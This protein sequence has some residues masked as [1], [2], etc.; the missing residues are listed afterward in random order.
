MQLPP[1]KTSCFKSFFK[2]SDKSTELKTAEIQFAVSVACHCSIL[3]IDHIGE[4]IQKSCK[5][6]LSNLKLHR[7]KCTK[8]ISNVV[9][10][11]LSEELKKDVKGQPFSLMVDES[12]DCSSEKLLCVCIRYFSD[13]KAEIVTAFLSLIPVNRTTGEALFDAVKKCLEEYELDLCQCIGFASDGANNM[14]GERN[15]LWSRIKESNPNCIQLKCICHSLALC[16]QKAFNKLPS[17]LDFLLSEVASWFSRSS[18]RRESYHEICGIMNPDEAQISSNPFQK[19]AL[20]RW[21]SRGKVMFNL[22]QNW[23][24]LK[25]YFSIVEVPDDN[26]AK[27]RAR[28]IKDMLFDDINYL[29][30]H[31][32]Y[33]IVAEFEKVNAM[34]QST[35]ADPESLMKELHLHHQSLKSRLYDAAGNSFSMNLIGFGAKFL[36]ETQRCLRQHNA[37]PKFEISVREMKFRC[38]AMLEEAL[39][40]VT[41]RLPEE[42]LV[43]RG[44]SEL[45]PRKCLSQMSRVPFSQ[46]PLQ[47]LFGENESDIENQYRK[48]LLHVWEEEDVFQGQIPMDSVEFWKGILHYTNA[49]KSH[50]YK[51]L[52]EYALSCLSVP[53]S[54]AVVE[55]IFSTVNLTKTDLRNRMGIEVLS[56]IVRIRTTLGFETKC[57]VNFNVSQNMLSNFTNDMYKI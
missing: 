30:F 53:V 37:D 40:Q 26:E 45:N 2:A 50:P 12:T 1:E 39:S 17:A 29:Y 6:H 43:F 9:A 11:S 56:S 32:A 8:I 22:L 21:L 48:L 24:E 51:E 4:I 10:K 57:C 7:T 49:T 20:T 47:H 55:R 41:M 33:P 3:A 42:K 36:S 16:I 54:N 15:S 31:F 38:K 14:I 13:A 27:Y 18:L 44:L 19:L 28:I 5:C 52:A 35:N 34:F 23:H 46:L 25:A